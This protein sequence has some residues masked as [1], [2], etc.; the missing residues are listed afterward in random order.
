M[1]LKMNLQKGFIHVW[2]GKDLIEHVHVWK[3]KAGV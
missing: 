1:P 2:S 3:P